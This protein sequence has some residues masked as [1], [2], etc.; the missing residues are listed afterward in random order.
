MCSLPGGDLFLTGPGE[1]LRTGIL[2]LEGGER[3][4]SSPTVN[5]FLTGDPP[6]VGDLC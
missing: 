6:L 2:L 4:G 5:L 1:L 3:A